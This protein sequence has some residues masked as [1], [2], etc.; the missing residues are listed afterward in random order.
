MEVS[1]NL[2]V[3]PAHRS[4]VPGRAL[5][6]RHI[7]PHVY[8]VLL[9]LALFTTWFSPNASDATVVIPVADTALAQ[10]ASA[11]V[12]GK[13][14]GLHSDW[15]KNR[16]H[17]FTRINLRVSEVLKGDVRTRGLTVT[18]YGGVVGDVESWIDG[19]PKFTVGEKVL[20]F[21]MQRTDG[22]FH[23][24]HLYQGK[25]SLFTDSDSGTEFAYREAHP[26]GV[27]V[28]D[29]SHLREHRS[30]TA[31]SS[32]SSEVTQSGFLPL[33]DLK[34]RIHNA[35]TNPSSSSSSQSSAPLAPRSSTTNE[36]VREEVPFSLLG[37]PAARWFQ[38]DSG[39]AVSMR[40][41]TAY[42]PNGSVSPLSSTHIASIQRALDVWTGVSGSSFQ[43]QNGGNI[44]STTTAR[45]MA[46]DNI[47][48]ISFGD[49]L[50]QIDPP[51]NCSGVLAIGGYYRSGSTT[52]VVNGVTYFQILEGD[53][54]FADGWTGCGFYENSANVAEVATHELGHVLALGHSADTTATMYAYA[55]F[56]GRDASIR[57]D[58]IAGLQAIYPSSSSTSPPCTYTVS[59]LSVSIGA[60]GTST[61]VS[62]T[63]SSNSCTW[64]ATSN[65][66]WIS[67]TTGASGTGNGS[68]ALTMVAN[69]SSSSRSGTV[70]IA[71]RTVTIT[72]A[73]TT[74]TSCTYTVSPLSVSVGAS[75][76]SSSV[77]VTPSPSA[78]AWTAVSNVNWITVTSGA[79]GAGNGSVTFS[80]AANSSSSSRSGT[81]TIGGR[82]ITV[83]QAAASTSSS[84]SYSVSDS[85]FSVSSSSTLKNVSVATSSSACSWNATSNTSWIAITAGASVLGNGVG[86]FTIE[87]NPSNLPRRGTLT[88]AGQTVIIDQAGKP[89]RK[90]R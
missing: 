6:S 43:F 27:H 8:R 41:N 47:N 5:V 70:T 19:T 66:S 48:A 40:I 57:A 75:G 79:S 82:T 32:T 44:S 51:A 2:P 14:T 68:V 38:P 15:D 22:T 85:S 89:R 71:G 42:S 7:L 9:V 53:L 23:V 77:T 61:N 46:N 3:S 49:P 35:L 17:I 37:S 12:I 45:G 16:Q 11:I 54:T 69:T 21:L 87:A 88:V 78:C 4:I 36:I 72:Q 84:C 29:G 26:E 56:D 81:L 55:H 60:T 31:T 1:M 65:A 59:P 39:Q 67:V 73:G 86:T 63:P 58:D 30:A 24:L 20:L 34:A 83:N 28:M 74:T 33:V 13:I 80:I 18:S 50:G 62:V 25:F 76:S 52:R 10:Q 64:T 90:A